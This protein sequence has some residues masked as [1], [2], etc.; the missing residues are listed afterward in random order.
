[1]GSE[2]DKR[3]C[4]HQPSDGVSADLC[5]QANWRIAVEESAQPDVKKEALWQSGTAWHDTQ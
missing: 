3:A 5:K 2:T 4:R 1:M